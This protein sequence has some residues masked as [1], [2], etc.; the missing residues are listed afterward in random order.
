VG[1]G[2]RGLLSF[3]A[4]FAVSF[5]VFVCFV[6]FCFSFVLAVK[7]FLQN[8]KQLHL[9]EVSP[10]SLMVNRNLF[11]TNCLVKKGAK[12]EKLYISSGLSTMNVSMNRSLQTVKPYYSSPFFCFFLLFFLLLL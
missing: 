11:R 3:A 7:R 12:Q 6:L 8:H 5:F 1:G 10:F 9:R 2:P 4:G